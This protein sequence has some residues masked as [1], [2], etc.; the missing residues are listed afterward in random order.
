M[1][2]D[3]RDVVEARADTGQQRGF[4]DRREHGAL[5]RELLDLVKHRLA[6][7]AI[8]LDALVT[9]QRVDVGIAAVRTSCSPR[10]AHLDP[11][12]RVPVSGAADSC[13][14]LELLLLVAPV[15]GWAPG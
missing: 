3:R 10:A 15:D 4:H 2:G 14:L 11:S 7:L 6:P 1:A 9:E 8:H 5:V 13:E 12:G